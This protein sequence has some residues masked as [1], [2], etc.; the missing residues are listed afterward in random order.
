MYV[1]MAAPV[2]PEGKLE[3][4]GIGS[5]GV[6]EG[7]GRSTIVVVERNAE[8]SMKRANPTKAASYQRRR[9]SRTM[10]VSPATPR[11]V[12]VLPMMVPKS[13]QVFSVAVRW[14]SIHR[15]TLPSHPTIPPERDDRVMRKPIATRTIARIREP[16][17]A[18]VA[19][20]AGGRHLRRRSPIARLG[21][22][23]PSTDRYPILRFFH[24]N[25][26]SQTSKD[27][28]ASERRSEPV[29]AA[30]RPGTSIRVDHR[31]IERPRP[32]ALP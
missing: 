9:I 32:Q 11:I 16:A 15:S 22:P 27:G 29:L 19:A 25:G 4:T 14:S 10:I 23:A 2:C 1:T 18:M 7:R 31:A 3:V 21:P 13:V 28:G 12:P 20:T 26:R 6:I 30:E 8:N 5:S 24:R 17:I